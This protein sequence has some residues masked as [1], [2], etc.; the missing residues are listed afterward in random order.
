MI[1]SKTAISYL[2]IDSLSKIY[3]Q[4][5]NEVHALKNISFILDKGEFITIMRP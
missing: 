2:V 3:K 1:E 4:G 5:D